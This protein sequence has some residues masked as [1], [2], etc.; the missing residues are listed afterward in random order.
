MTTLD[1]S[2]MADARAI[3]RQ[4]RVRYAPR[5]KTPIVRWIERE[6]VV[7]QDSGAANPGPYRFDTVPWWREVVEYFAADEGEEVV[8]AKS[9]QVGYTELLMAFVA[10]CMAEDPSSMLMIQPDIE[11]AESWSKERLEPVLRDVP[12]VKAVMRS[13]TKGMAR[14]SDDTMRRKMFVGGWLAI[15]G[16]NSAAGLASRPVRRLLGDERDRWAVSAGNEGDP[17]ELGKKRSI[18]FWNRKH[19]KGGTPKDEDGSPTWS[20]WLASDMRQWHVPCPHCG[21]YQPFRWRDDAGQYH[22]VCDRDAEGRLIPETAQYRCADCQCLIDERRKAAMVAKGR[23]VAEHPERELRGYHIWSAYSPWMTWAQIIKEFEASRGIETKL[24]TFVNTILGLPFAPAAEKID[25]T[26]LMA[27][28]EPMPEVPPEFGLLTAG[29][30]VQGDR[31]E[32]TVMA[33]GPGECAAV[34]EYGIVNGDPGQRETWDE[35]TAELVK[36]RGDLRVSAVAA[37]TGYLPEKV[38]TW[39]DTRLPFK[40]FATKGMPNRGRLIMQKPGAVTHKR[41][42]RPWLLGTDTAK[43]ALA[44]RLRT[45]PPGP[46]S[47]RFAETLPPE[48]YDHLTAEKLTTAYV[49]TRPVKRWELQAGRRN[50]GLDLTILCLAALHGLGVPTIQ[51]LGTLAQRRAEKRQTA[52]APVTKSA[53]TEHKPAPTRSP[54]RGGWVN[55][56]KG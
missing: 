33:W 7:T 11:R 5:S 12:A 38:W 30:D 15:M 29:V 4:A 6:Y 49:G 52:A 43:D 42:R 1:T 20:D 55:S 3:Y 56:W 21:T 27:R 9:A 22:I 47:I 54:R 40:V 44:A 32:Y 18:T 37:D 23:W 14:S 2:Q 41:K 50:E 16:S 46:Q 8:V 10:W 53:D 13:K 39:G 24:Q 51:S 35:L 25:P 48:F 36:P 34:M 45:Q 31:L 17:F 19:I 26:T 28:A